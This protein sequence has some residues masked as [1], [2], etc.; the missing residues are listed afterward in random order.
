M[1][2]FITISLFFLFLCQK[3]CNLVIANQVC[4]F[5]LLF[6]I[7]VFKYCSTIK[8]NIIMKKLFERVYDYVSHLL[9]GNESATHY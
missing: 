2:L 5:D 4:C 7:G 1:Y 9:F 6:F 3:K 8:K